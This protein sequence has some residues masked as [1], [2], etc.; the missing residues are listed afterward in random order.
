MGEFRGFFSEAR[1]KIQCLSW[2]RWNLSPS[3]CLSVTRSSS[4]LLVCECGWS[5]VCQCLSLCLRSV[6]GTVR[7]SVARHT[8]RSVPTG[9]YLLTHSVLI[10]NKNH[11]L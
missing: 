4:I 3:V 9:R 11:R 7:Y 10:L 8:A 6:V 5:V 2:Q 1:G